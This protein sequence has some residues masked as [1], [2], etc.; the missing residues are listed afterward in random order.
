[1]LYIGS[2]ILLAY[3]LLKV[4][5]WRNDYQDS[6][7]LLRTGNEPPRRF[8]DRPARYAVSSPGSKESHSSTEYLL[9]C[10]DIVPALRS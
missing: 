10:D 3:W 4:S 6:R 1:M 9:D 5:D 2:V 7:V 8:S